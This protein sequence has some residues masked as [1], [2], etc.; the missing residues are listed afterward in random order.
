MSQS[1]DL[2]RPDEAA[3]N[4]RDP[5]RAMIE[6]QR[7]LL[8]AQNER[9]ETE[10]VGMLP[11]PPKLSYDTTSRATINDGLRK[12]YDDCTLGKLDE[13][14]Q[15][16]DEEEPG[17]DYLQYGLTNAAREGHADIVRYLFRKGAQLTS[18]VL[19]AGCEKPTLSF[20]K[21]LVEEKSWHPNQAMQSSGVALPYCVANE[22]VL[23]YLLD[24]GADPSLGA[25]PQA[26]D[27]SPPTDRR[28]GEAL[29]NAA[30]RCQPRIIDLLIEHG[31]KLEYARPIHRAALAHSE[32]NDRRPMIQHLIDLGVDL[33]GGDGSRPGSGDT[34]LSAVVKC[35]RI[36][37]AEL[38]LDL[39][40][41]PDG[42]FEKPPWYTALVEKV[43]ARKGNDAFV[44]DV[45]AAMAKG[46][47]RGAY[48]M[49]YIP[50]VHGIA[51]T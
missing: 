36:Q 13:V 12:F 5:E 27:P 29:N 50:Q 47:A 35:E 28:S 38:L 41:H 17:V 3:D 22:E 18:Q 11:L 7:R 14:K 21:C 45:K 43:K 39:G 20:F 37:A 19:Y 33:N 40:A 48:P 8:H 30:V 10:F 6:S 32:Q 16:V 34:P 9:L 31:A 42:P 24:L 46:I 1:S 25:H 26:F 51:G 15:Y 44:A 49:P 4:I 2:S 23:R